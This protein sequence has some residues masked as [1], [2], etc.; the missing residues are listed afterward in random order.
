MAL[1]ILFVKGINDSEREIKGLK[2]LV[3][4]IEPHE[5]HLNTVV[6]PPAEDVEAVDDE[7]L[8]QVASFFGESAIVVGRSLCSVS[9]DK[10]KLIEA[11]I[12]TVKRRPLTAEDIASLVG[13]DKR[14]VDKI[15]ERLVESGKLEEVKF[16]GKRF[17]RLS[18]DF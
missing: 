8:F 10:D 4:Y 3:E 9:L 7:F 11:V 2:K 1:E 17:Y 18:E 13:E 14:V 16:S 5:V 15:I 12:D 6:R